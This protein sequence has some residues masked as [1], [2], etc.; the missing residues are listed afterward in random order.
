MPVS[1]TTI[2]I[3]TYG[4]GNSNSLWLLAGPDNVL[5]VSKCNKTGVYT[6]WAAVDREVV[7][8]LVPNRKKMGNMF[9]YNVAPI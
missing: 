6:S 9:P 5:W 7:P 8:S 3:T 2:E 1:T 4:N